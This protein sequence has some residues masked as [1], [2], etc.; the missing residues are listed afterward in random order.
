M[1]SK[2]T[3]TNLAVYNDFIV[4]NLNQEVI[5][6]AVYTDLISAFDTVNN[7]LLIRKLAA[8][9]I[10]GLLLKLFESYLN[11]RL[12]YVEVRGFISYIFEVSSGVGQGTYLGFILCIIF[13]N[14]AYLLIKFSQILFCADDTKI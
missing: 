12:Q 3:V 9:G 2:S 7:E 5:V 8:Y 11:D 13:I 1:K 14:D 6:E 4:S 10:N